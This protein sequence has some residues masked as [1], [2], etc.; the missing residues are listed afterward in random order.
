MM[1]RQQRQALLQA[2]RLRGD[3]LFPRGQ[4]QQAQQQGQ[5]LQGQR[6]LLSTVVRQPMTAP[7]SENPIVASRRAWQSHRQANPIIKK[8]P[9]AST[10]PVEE[11]PWPKSVVYGTYVAA[12]TLIPYFTAWFIASNPVAREFVSKYIVADVQDHLRGHFGKPE[13][14]AVSYSD[15]I[16][17]TIDKREP[18]PYV[19]PEE[20]SLKVRR[21]QAAVQALSEQP[22][23]VT[24]QLVESSSTSATGIIT[25]D[26][27]TQ[28]VPGSTLARPETLL[29]FIMPSESQSSSSSS[30]SSSSNLPAIAVDFLSDD[31]DTNDNDD[32]QRGTV[33]N[34]SSDS[35]SSMDSTS[36][37]W[38][39][40]DL[41]D[42]QAIGGKKSV[43]P[44]QMTANIFSSW[45][46]QQPAA[47]ATTNSSSS[48]KN[49]NSNNSNKNS[50]VSVDDIERS[51]LEYRIAEL[52]HQ[53]KDPNNLRS[54]DDIVEELN[55]T[56]SELGTLKWNK[57]AWRK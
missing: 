30:A 31:D 43:D 8:D 26:V 6:R 14:S 21:E 46:Y 49:N 48:N 22:V 20:S 36:T 40:G 29:A 5:R 34:F 1:Q 42:L 56:K 18:I 41:N 27:R 11:T 53:L 32:S 16:D 33:T 2:R 3:L 35:S 4:A 24:I 13:H 47:V 50:N 10:K 57:W 39:S 37:D 55:Q 9:A 45:H 25:G 28:K 38:T 7:P 52:Q 12:A 15:T 17:N 54:K 19:L 23:T 51:R 44:L